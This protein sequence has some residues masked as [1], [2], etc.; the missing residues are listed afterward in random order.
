MKNLFTAIL[1]VFVLISCSSNTAKETTESKPVIDNQKVIVDNILNRR[2]VRSY[3]P[4]QV[5]KSKIDTILL[6]AINAPSANNKQPWEVRVIQNPELLNKIKAINEKIYHNSPTIIIVARDTKNNFSSFDC[7]LLTQNILLSAEAMGLGTCTLGG[8]G[9]LI[10]SAEGTE[11]R[12]ALNLSPDYETVVGIS[13]GYK[14]ETP[15]AKPRDN[16][17]AQYID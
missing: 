14:N 4:E 10:N 2:S 7:G 6:S 5:D 17:K 9:R 1:T 16:N 12:E 3:K 13:L 11:I 15:E 8:L